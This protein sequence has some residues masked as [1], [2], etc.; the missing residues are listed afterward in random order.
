M[1][2]TSLILPKTHLPIKW[3]F[4]SSLNFLEAL[5]EPLKT[6]YVGEAHTDVVCII[7]N[8][9]A[10]IKE[11]RLL[12]RLAENESDYWRSSDEVD[13]ISECPAALAQG[14]RLGRQ[15][16]SFTC[17]LHWSALDPCTAV[18]Q[19]NCWLKING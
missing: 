5:N 4:F 14:K 11:E 18:T 10:G 15:K 19:C 1:A 2:H 3:Q 13:I 8:W 16:A 6:A 9:W 17:I 12:T 7:I